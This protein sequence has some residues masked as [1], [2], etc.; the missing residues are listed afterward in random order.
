M[1][2]PISLKPWKTVP[3]IEMPS[4][5]P[6]VAQTEVAQVLP[7]YCVSAAKFCILSLL[8]FGLYDIFWF[9]KNWSRYKAHSGDKLSPFWRAVFSPLFCY[10][11]A[12]KVNSLSKENRIQQRLEPATLAG[13]YLVLMMLSRLPDPYWLISL[14]SFLP[15]L[16]IVKQ[17][18]R[19]HESIRPGYDST[20]GWGLGAFAVV[21]LGGI[22]FALA[23]LGTFMVPSQAL[24]G[25]EIP[26]AY[27]ATLVEEGILRPEET[28]LFFYSGGLFSILEDGNL[29]TDERVISYNGTEED[30]WMASAPYG[31]IQDFEIEYSESVLS[32][33]ILTIYPQDNEEFVLYVSSEGGRDREFVAFL[34]SRL[35]KNEKTNSPVETG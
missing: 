19:I 3:P 16:S 29:L 33:T 20:Q 24:L 34:Q 2:K 4:E 30:F 6:M 11:L 31:E 23:L 26:S 15:L 22:F 13:L 35:D 1:D 10:S 8:T 9:Y 21:F 32:D 28:I 12:N 18:R 27:Q 14:F 7:F 25:S 5:D 17:I